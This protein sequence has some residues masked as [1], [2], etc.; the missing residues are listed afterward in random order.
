MCLGE[1]DAGVVGPTPGSAILAPGE[2]LA[3]YRVKGGGGA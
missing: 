1:E 3:C 2:P